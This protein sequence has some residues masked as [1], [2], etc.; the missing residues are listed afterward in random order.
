M[1]ELKPCPFCGSDCL[2]VSINESRGDNVAIE[3]I[4]CGC[5]GP[6]MHNQ[7]AAIEEWNTRK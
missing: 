2:R 6:D 4:M 3:C 5:M 7:S 1:S